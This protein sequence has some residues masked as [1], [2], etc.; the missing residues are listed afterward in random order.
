MVQ[1][2]NKDLYF[3]SSNPNKFREIEPI[4]RQYGIVSQLIKMSIQEIQSESVH[5]IA[6]DK[7]TYAF[8]HL[9]RPVVIEDDGFYISSLNGFPGQYSSFVYKTLGN[10]GILKLMLNK[11]NRRAYFLSVIAYN[12]GHTLK[13]FSGKTQGMLSKAAA[14][15]GWGFDPIFLPKNTNKTYAELGR[16]N[17]KSFYSHRRKSIEKFSK[18]YITKRLQSGNR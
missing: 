10:Q 18:W 16:L 9:L 13:M 7:S 1:L 6:E 8:K 3:V 12:D 4:L 11:V 14:E 15:G 5:R 17:R 2:K